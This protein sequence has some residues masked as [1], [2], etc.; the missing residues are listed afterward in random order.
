MGEENLNFKKWK[1]EAKLL[2]FLSLPPIVLIWIPNLIIQFIGLGL[3]LVTVSRL[4]YIVYIKNGS[5]E[6]RIENIK[7]TRL[8]KQ[9]Q[10]QTEKNLKQIKYLLMGIAGSMAIG[11]FFW[12][13][14]FGGFFAE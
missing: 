7:Q 10:N 14:V 3:L 13:L 2:S 9:N 6:L 5:K 8:A 12:A 4:M 1:E 11:F